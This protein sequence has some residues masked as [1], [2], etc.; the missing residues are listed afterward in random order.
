[1]AESFLAPEGGGRVAGADENVVGK[2]G[3]E[4]GGQ[5]V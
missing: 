1:M 3:K 5:L 2:V 4:N